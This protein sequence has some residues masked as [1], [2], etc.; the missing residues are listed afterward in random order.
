AGKPGPRG[1]PG[2]SGGGAPGARGPAAAEGG[3]K[4]EN[5]ARLAR[6]EHRHDVRMT[7]AGRRPRL[8]H[9]ALPQL[10]RQ[11]RLRP[12]DLERDLA[13]Q[14]RIDGQVNDAKAPGAEEADEAEPP[15]LGKALGEAEA[16][17]VGTGGGALPAPARSPILVEPLQEIPKT[18]PAGRQRRAARRFLSRQRPGTALQGLVALG[19]PGGEFLIGRRNVVT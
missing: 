11:E 8:A 3:H 6:F 1:G 16:L 12:R 5:G 19:G 7:Q 4:K 9:E 2:P 17:G 15:E 18:L 14:P 10:G 13:M